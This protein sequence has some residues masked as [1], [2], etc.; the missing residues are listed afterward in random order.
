MIGISSY[1]EYSLDIDV[2]SKLAQKYSPF[3]VLID[4]M[5]RLTID[6]IFSG[7]CDVID[8]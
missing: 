4:H 3:M 2:A 5:P 7:L 8:E 1:Q 6:N